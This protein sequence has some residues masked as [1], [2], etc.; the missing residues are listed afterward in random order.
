[1]SNRQLIA[2]SLLFAAAAPLAISAFS[3][4]TPAPTNDNPPATVTLTGVVRDFKERTVNGGHPDMERQPTNGFAHYCDNVHPILGEDKVKNQ[5]RNA[6]GKNICWRLYN[7]SLGDIQG[8]K[9]SGVVDTGGIQNAASFNKWYNDDLAFN[10]SAPL[11]LTLTRQSNGAYVFDSNTDPAC[12][13]L[14]GFFPIEN[15]LFGNPGGTPNRNFHFTFEL[16]TKFTY[17]ADGNQ[18][19]SFRG[20]DDVWVYIDGKLVIDLGGVHGAVEQEVQLNRLGLV[21]GQEYDLDFFFAERHRTQS[22]FKIT[23]NL[24]LSNTVL[25]TISNAYD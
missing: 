10:V 18:V 23:T 20:D 16:H 2:R 25:P 13:A 12:V 5:W 19:F 3:A 1:M 9:V 7:A 21:D 11:S 15:Q 22:N 4:S 17:D 8:S 14:G 6:A 24:L